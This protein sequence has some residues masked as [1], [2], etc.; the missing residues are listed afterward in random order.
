MRRSSRSWLLVSLSLLVPSAA[1][2]AQPLSSAAEDA[3]AAGAPLFSADER[4]AVG[5]CWAGLDRLGLAR[6]F[7]SFPGA[8]QR[9]IMSG[10]DR[11]VEFLRERLTELIDEDPRR[12]NTVLDWAQRFDER[13]MTAVF[14]EALS[15]SAAV[16]DPQIRNRLL[17]MADEHGDPEHQAAA[18]AMLETQRSFDEA[19][20]NTLEEVA[21]ATDSPLSR[22]LAIR[23]IGSVMRGHAA[24]A[25]RG[26]CR[27]EQCARMQQSLLDIGNAADDIDAQRLAV[28]MISD[29][30]AATSPDI[31]RQLGDLLQSGSTRWTRQMAS[32][33]LAQSGNP[34]QALEIYRQAFLAEVDFC[35]RVAIFRDAAAAAGKRA[36]PLMAE[37]AAVEPRLK[38][39]HKLFAELYATGV[40][41][42]DRVVLELFDKIHLDCVEDQDAPL[43]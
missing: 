35:T 29:P 4:P 26:G 38:P 7:E 3:S 41:D 22:Q 18:I 6:S 14:A 28:E 31:V 37:L 43:P 30:P 27:A 19:A 16:H 25:D 42:F 13:A 15:E 9:A 24:S 21:V 5:S 8:V 12:A 32:L 10:D 11:L 1:A 20:L 39:D 2:L 17:G 36:L 40:V 33:A 34:D 23:T